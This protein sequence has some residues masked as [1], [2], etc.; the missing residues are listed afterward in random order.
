MRVIGEKKKNQEGKGSLTK[1]KKGDKMVHYMHMYKKN[2][3]MHK[4]K[5]RNK[6]KDIEKL[7]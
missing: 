7:Y 1:N 6:N 2:S 3:H 4:Y 5:D